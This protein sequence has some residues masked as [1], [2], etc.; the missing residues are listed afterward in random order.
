MFHQKGLCSVLDTG[1]YKVSHNA[2]IIFLTKSLVAIDFIFMQR[3]LEQTQL[4]TK[5][6]ICQPPTST[7][8]EI[9]PP[10]TQPPHQAVHTLRLYNPQELP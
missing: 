2:Q 3:T 5:R 10:Q 9:H 6:S 1:R 8:T 7:F 4:H